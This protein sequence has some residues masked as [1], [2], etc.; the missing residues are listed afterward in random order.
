[1][2]RPWEL[3]DYLVLGAMYFF[4]ALSFL[5]A[6]FAWHHRVQTAERASHWSMAHGEILQSELV[7]ER[8][9]DGDDYIPRVRYAWTAHGKRWTGDRIRI[10]PGMSFKD[11]MLAQHALAP[12]RA[13]ERVRVWYDPEKPSRAVLEREATGAGLQPWLIMGLFLLGAAAYTNLT[14]LVPAPWSDGNAHWNA[15]DGD[16]AP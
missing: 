5:Y 7:V 13:G 16:D 6:V 15:D 9:S 4:G 14:M 3:S 11:R 2:L 10:G 12:Y 8:D 1:M